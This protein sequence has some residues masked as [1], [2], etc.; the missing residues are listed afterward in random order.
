MSWEIR[1]SSSSVTKEIILRASG[2]DHVKHGRYSR[3]WFGDHTFSSPIVT[4]LI[5]GKMVKFVCYSWRSKEWRMYECP[6]SEAVD[7]WKKQLKTLFENLETTKWIDAEHPAWK[8]FG[9][10]M[11]DSGYQ[12]SFQSAFG[13][14]NKTM[15]ELLA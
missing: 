3:V 14:L 5:D 8:E 11:A 6:K 12:L 15:Y 9:K 4:A 7:D 13:G 1:V 10:M 2:G